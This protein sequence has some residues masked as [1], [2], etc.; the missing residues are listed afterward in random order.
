MDKV[1][2]FVVDVVVEQLKG[3]S[4]DDD[5]VVVVPKT[6]SMI[7]VVDEN[8]EAEEVEVEEGVD[9]DFLEMFDAAVEHG[10]DGEE[11]KGAVNDEG[12]GVVGLEIVDDVIF[13]LAVNEVDKETDD[14]DEIAF[15]VVNFD[16]FVDLDNVDDADRWL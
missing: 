4:F 7:D 14:D 1:V 6:S 5:D 15:W 16:A 12:V 8:M 2:E 9:A 11:E 10:G 13:V 3:G